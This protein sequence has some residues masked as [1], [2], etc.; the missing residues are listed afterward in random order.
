MNVYLLERDKD[1][2]PYDEF[3]GFVVV[4][5]DE[6]QAR[7]LPAARRFATDEWPPDAQVS[8]SLIATEAIGEPRIVLGSFN[9]G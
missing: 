6:D 5:N 2:V 7:L 8:V 3:D 9:A 4:A 1:K